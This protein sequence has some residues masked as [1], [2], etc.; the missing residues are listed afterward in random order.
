M[1]DPVVTA[2]REAA[3]HRGFRLL[4]SRVRTPGK[5]DY[6]KFG[7]TDPKGK[8]VLGVGDDGLSA[9]AGD[10]EAFLR[11]GDV[12]FWRQSAAAPAPARP[13]RTRATPAREGHE[14]AGAARRAK[15]SRRQPA[16][17]PAPVPS[18]KER[19]EP[20]REPPPLRYR[21]AVPGDASGLDALLG[22]KGDARGDAGHRMAAC[23]KAGGG[24]LVAERGTTLVACLAWLP[25][26]A[27]HRAPSGRI[28]TLLVAERRRREG[29]GTA[30]VEQAAGLLAKAGCASI[31]AMSDIEIRSAHGFFRKLGFEETSYRFARRLDKQSRK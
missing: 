16:R 3:A 21:S 9:S 1:A 20:K 18:G 30:L 26:P 22:L 14:P 17:K 25:V 19:R 31:E 5:G 10:I 6:G 24:V 2:L 27:L 23:R 29:I 28:A 13:K 7:L 12:E 4:A 8:P 11:R 15:T